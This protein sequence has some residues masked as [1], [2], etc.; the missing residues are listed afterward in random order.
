[1]RAHTHCYI[2]SHTSYMLIRSHILTHTLQAFT[3][4]SMHTHSHTLIYIPTFTSM[5]Y[6]YTYTHS[7]T[8]L[9]YLHPNTFS[10]ERTQFTQALSPSLLP[11]L[12]PPLFPA[13]TINLS[14]S[15]LFLVS[16]KLHLTKIS[17]T[18]EVWHPPCWRAG[19]YWSV[20]KS[21]HM[22]KCYI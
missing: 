6:T 22:E 16:K 1:M 21:K 19:F 12:L 3:Y 2:Q 7:L 8:T 14:H 15:H 17:K 5:T 18:C 4:S 11:S 10:H 9:T 13:D 20:S